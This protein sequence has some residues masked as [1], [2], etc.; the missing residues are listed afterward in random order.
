MGTAICVGACYV[1][2]MRVDLCYMLAGTFYMRLLHIWCILA[3]IQPSFLEIMN[4]CSS[5][6]YIYIYIYPPASVYRGHK[7]VVEICSL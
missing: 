4:V 3:K 7:A 6:I 1:F 2:Y 5:Y